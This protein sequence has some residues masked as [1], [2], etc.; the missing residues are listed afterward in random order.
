[1]VELPCVGP[2]PTWLPVRLVKIS[3]CFTKYKN[4][5]SNTIFKALYGQTQIVNKNTV[6]VICQNHSSYRSHDFDFSE[7]LKTLNLLVHSNT[8]H[9][10][11]FVPPITPSTL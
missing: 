1:M 7:Y 5:S 2:L 6:V 3:Y 4:K 8:E 10:P 11:S 9:L